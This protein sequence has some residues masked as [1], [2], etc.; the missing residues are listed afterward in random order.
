MF[1]TA[2]FSSSRQRDSSVKDEC[3]ARMN[4]N[5]Y[6]WENIYRQRQVEKYIQSYFKNP[7]R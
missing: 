3:D 2:C 1:G 6:F 4:Q 7:Q 5:L